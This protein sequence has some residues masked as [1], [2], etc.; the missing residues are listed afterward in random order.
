MDRDIAVALLDQLHAAQNEF[1]G[2]GGDALPR[3]LLVSDIG[4]TVPGNNSVAGVCRGTEAVFDY[5]RRRGLPA[6]TFPGDYH[7]VRYQSVWLM[8]HGLSGI[9]QT[10]PAAADPGVGR[11]CPRPASRSTGERRL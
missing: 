2:G 5:F 9:A 3:D 10:R 11:L 6:G 7:A 8:T 4:W 1:Y